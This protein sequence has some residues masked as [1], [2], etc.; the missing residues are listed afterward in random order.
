MDTTL[1]ISSEQKAA[2]VVDRAEFEWVALPEETEDEKRKKEKDA[3]HK[4][5]KLHLPGHSK[6]AASVE[7]EED[8]TEADFVAS[9]P[10][11]I[12]NMSLEIAQGSLVAICGPVGSGSE[13]A[14]RSWVYPDLGR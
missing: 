9:D 7:D 2:L 12:K 3:K 6:K 4:H 8:S 11:R 14:A 5:G 10:F 13:Y 1:S